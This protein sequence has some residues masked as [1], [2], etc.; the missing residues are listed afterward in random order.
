MVTQTPKSRLLPHT[1]Q[2]E[3]T[4]GSIQHM[5]ARIRNHW[6]ADERLDRQHQALLFQQQLLQACGLVP[7]DGLE[8]VITVAQ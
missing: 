4:S 2:Q 3:P 8:E 1:S 5:A 7:S 6:T